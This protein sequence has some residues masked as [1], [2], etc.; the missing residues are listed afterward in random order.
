M[1]NNRH[2]WRWLALIFI[3]FGIML[4]M[5]LPMFTGSL[6]PGD[7]EWRSAWL[8][9][10]NFALICFFIA[11][12]L[13]AIIFARIIVRFA[14][15]VFRWL[16]SWRALKLFLR[17]LAALLVFMALF[18]YVE[19]NWRA[20]RA[21]ENYR[22]EWEA[23]GERFDFASF[24]PPPVADDRN[25]ALT[26]I[27]AT[28]YEY[29]LDKNGH[30]IKPPRTNVVERLLMRV[31]HWPP[32]DTVSG[33][34]PT[35]G[36][37]R[38]GRMCDLKSWQIYYRTPFTNVFW[39][40]DENSGSYWKPF[41]N[42]ASILTNDFAFP[43][44][45]QSPA[46]DVLLALSKYDSDIE[47]LRNAS[48]LPDSRFPLNYDAKWPYAIYLMHLYPLKTCC[49]LLR[50]R[51][52]AELQNN[53]SDR[54]LADVKLSLRL[55]DSIRNEPNL[56]SH[57]ERVDML[58]M[59][60]QPVWEALA[61]HKW[62]D[63][64]LTQLDQQLAEFDFL[65]DFEF[66]TRGERAAALDAIEF[67]R[68]HRTSDIMEMENF[69]IS[70]FGL[71]EPKMEI[72]KETAK[73][74]VF[75]LAP[76]SV[77]YENKLNY[78][79]IYQQSLLPI[80]NIENRTVSPGKAAKFSAEVGKLN[81]HWFP[82]NRLAYNLLPSLESMLRKFAYA[83][84]SVDMA[85]V[86]CALE[87]YHLAQGEY[88]ETLDALAPQFMEKIPHDIIGGQPLHYHRTADGKFLLYSVGWNETDDGG[89]VNLREGSHWVGNQWIPDPSDWVWQYP[90]N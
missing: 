33:I 20:R 82:N 27:V 15:N 11:G 73:R 75:L 60:I 28:S 9:L 1:N 76:S 52:V 49:E 58:N 68:R 43:A 3:L 71:P 35:N 23:K 57:R 26:P 44:S 25:F 64:Q 79:R 38:I 7:F 55:I 66:S 72:L 22:R 78:A 56:I 30:E 29:M 51:A 6:N 10:F 59:T 69:H 16:F 47:E 86:A 70:N 84:S 83:Q 5:F 21:W 40:V 63:S 74:V 65:A 4:A 17:A 54:A 37:W 42:P 39:F 90:Q 8:R 24:V 89:V 19:E 85:R 81:E 62:S 50:L 18:F 48:R 45:P 77:F 34:E 46:A 80:V 53:Q 12:L 32:G 2:L 61:E 67:M 14:R 41:T 13:A 31:N 87:R 36:D 88:P